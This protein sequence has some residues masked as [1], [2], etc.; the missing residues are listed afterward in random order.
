MFFRILEVGWVYDLLGKIIGAK[1]VRQYFV[2]H[3]V[4]PKP[5]LRILDIGCGPG[6]MVTY[7]SDG[8]YLGIDANPKYIK[9]AQ[10]RFPGKG[11]FL[12]CSIL[13]AIELGRCSF[14]V[15]I[16]FGILHHLDDKEAFR[17]FQLAFNSLKPGG[18]FVTLDGCFRDKQHF[19]AY[20]MNRLDRGKYVRTLEEYATLAR[21][22]FPNVRSFDY[23]G[24]LNLPFDYSV[25][26]CERPPSPH[27]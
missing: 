24:R 10:R 14:D 19:I 4:C 2:K 7:L 12:C 11:K 17:L 20:W 23:C 6:S 21:Q 18:R 13:N 27:K 1:A 25:L 22:V 8:E 5:G 9:R 15:A 26:I 16:G 3:Y